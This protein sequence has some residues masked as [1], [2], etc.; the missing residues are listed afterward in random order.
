MY[1]KIIILGCFSV[2][3]IFALL[4]VVFSTFTVTKL[5]ICLECKILLTYLLII[6]FLDLNS[7]LNPRCSD[8]KGTFVCLISK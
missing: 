7:F 8:I 4:K 6:S 5:L 1:L 3:Y 2:C